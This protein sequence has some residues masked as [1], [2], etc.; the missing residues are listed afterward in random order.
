MAKV[1]NDEE[2]GIPTTIMKWRC[3]GLTLDQWNVFM[4]D[5]SSITVAVNPNYMT[6]EE[7]KDIDTEEDENNE[8]VNTENS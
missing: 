4:R 3:D 2:D 7:L 6:R 5:P 8:N 1:K